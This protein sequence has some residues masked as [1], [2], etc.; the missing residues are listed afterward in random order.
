MAERKGL[1]LILSAPSGTGKTTLARR[2]LA[3][4]PDGLFSISVTTRSPRGRVTHGVDYT[5][6]DRAAFDGLV[7]RDELLEWAEVFGNRYGSPRGPALQALAEGRLCVFDIDVQ[8]GRQIKARHQEAATVF[9]LPP[10]LPELAR[11]L[12]GRAT[13]S[14]EVVARRLAAAETEIVEGLA[15]YGHVIVN[16]DLDRASADLGSLVR[17]LR[18][19]GSSADAD[20][21]AAL[22]RSAQDLTR[23]LP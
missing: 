9:V 11:R 13:D 18:G 15:S 6:V 10:S 14:P 16:D 7:A 8:G 22:S 5:F 12:K 21:A 17:H 3:S 19:E 2:L 4:V 20:R 23:F 1:L